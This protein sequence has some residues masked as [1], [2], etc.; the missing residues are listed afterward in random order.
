M[1]HHAAAA[2]HAGAPCDGA[3]SLTSVS[4]SLN[5]LYNCFSG[6]W[7]VTHTINKSGSLQAGQEYY[8]EHSV[9]RAAYTYW[10]RSSTEAK[11]YTD[12]TVGADNQGTGSKSVYHQARAY[13]VP[14]GESPPNECDAGS[15]EPVTS[16]EATPS[17]T[18]YNCYS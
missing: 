5:N 3:P 7:T 17:G 16:A 8:W 10:G 18:A 15:N 2:Q 14:I 12:A 11:Q 4:N 1:L 6:G 13:V 9:D